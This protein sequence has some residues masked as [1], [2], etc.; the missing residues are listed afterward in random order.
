M[1]LRDSRGISIVAAVLTLII[2]GIMAVALLG[3]VA[4]EQ[5]T[6]KMA[7]WRE[8]AFYAVQAGFEFALREIN[9]GGYP[10]ASD[11]PF[12]NAVFSISID[13]AQRRITVNGKAG[14]ASKTHSI[15]TQLLA[16]DCVSIDS[17]EAD[18]GGTNNNVLTGIAL[19]HSCLLAVNIKE[20]TLSW[21]PNYGGTVRRISIGGQDVYVNMGGTA[22][23]QPIDIADYKFSGQVGIDAIEFSSSMKNISIDLTL[24][25]TDTSSVQETGIIIHH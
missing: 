18:L 4:S 5:E 15:T 21:T 12:A 6:R 22:S 17:S 13:P 25:F 2:L 9:E 16:R 19:D 23:G 14:D 3:I 7:L 20:M 1:I 11:K 8:R 24:T 10:I